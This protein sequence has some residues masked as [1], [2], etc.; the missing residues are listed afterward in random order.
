MA[1]SSTLTKDPSFKTKKTSSLTPQNTIIL[2]QVSTDAGWLKLVKKTLKI[3]LSIYL[4]ES[5][6]F[7]KGKREKEN[8]T[9]HLIRI[10][11]KLV[12]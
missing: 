10:S 6:T 11:K 2:K 9:K 3:G 1:K 7:T 8:L 5:L 4:N 12:K